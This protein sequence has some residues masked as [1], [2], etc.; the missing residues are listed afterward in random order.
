MEPMFTTEPPLSD[1][2]SR[3]RKAIV[4]KKTEETF[5]CHTSA[6]SSKVSAPKI[7]DPNASGD[8]LGDENCSVLG[9]TLPALASESVWSPC[10]GSGGAY[11]FIKMS[12]FIS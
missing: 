9:P 12:S 8:W 6:Q 2:V 10:K 1:L 3:P 5:V 7:R 4:T 11:L